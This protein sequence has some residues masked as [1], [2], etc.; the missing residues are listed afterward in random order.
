[1]TEL[2]VRIHLPASAANLQQ[3]ANDFASVVRDCRG[4]SRCV[5]VTQWGVGDADSWIPGAFGGFGAATMFNQS[6]QP[7]PSFN[8]TLTALG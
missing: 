3:Q 7:K 2:D 6:Y 8:A 1:V 5:G 4:V